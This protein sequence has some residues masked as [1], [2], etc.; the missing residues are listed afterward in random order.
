[1]RTFEGGRGEIARLRVGPRGSSGGNAYKY[2]GSG[3][4]YTT[5][6][7]FAGGSASHSIGR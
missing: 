2:V 4:E 1:M 5:D 6:I 3:G 7:M